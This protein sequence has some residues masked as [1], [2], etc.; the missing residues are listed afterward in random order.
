MKV[1]EPTRRQ[2]SQ[3]L[4]TAVTGHVQTYRRAATRSATVSAEVSAVSP[5][6][7]VRKNKMW[8]R[9]DGRGRKLQKEEK[10]YIR[11]SPLNFPFGY[12]PSSATQAVL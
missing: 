7:K 6:R 1:M 3:D 8:L 10:I 9:I 4:V 2:G 12:R 11:Y 5:K